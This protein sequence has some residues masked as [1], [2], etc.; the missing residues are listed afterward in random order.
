MDFER[1][2]LTDRARGRWSEIVRALAPHPVMLQAIERARAHP[3]NAYG[4]KTECPVHIGKSGR[5]F[6]VLKDFEQ[7][8]HCVC[9]SCGSKKGFGLLMWL[10]GWDVRQTAVRLGAYL[11][12]PDQH[13][14]ARSVWG[15]PTQA[16]AADSAS[17][18]KGKSRAQLQ[19][20]WD[21]ASGLTDPRAEPVVRY[22]ASRGLAAATS[23]QTL[24]CHPGMPVFVE[25]EQSWRSYPTMLAQ[26]RDVNGELVGMHR[27]FVT[28]AGQK[29]PV[30]SPKRINK[31]AEAL[32]LAGASIQLMPAAPTLGTSEGI[33]NALSV[34]LATG[35]PMW[36]A[37]NATLL[38]ALVVPRW[39]QWL[40]DWA[41]Y[42]ELTQ[43]PN[44]TLVEPG[45]AAAERLIERHR[46]A[47]CR[48]RAVYPTMLGRRGV[49][50]NNVWCQKGSAGFPKLKLSI[51]VLPTVW[52]L[53]RGLLTRK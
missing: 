33:E 24:K 26:Y 11:D 9:N 20:W 6:R 18:P 21:E 14:P 41:D 40:V 2:R 28:E 48:V 13:A 29:A 31:A 36:P 27:T 47:F 43:L 37:G 5:A 30:P 34:F 10:N 19:A 50:W 51:G 8:G 38:G 46:G 49:D 39:V 15:Q 32:S 17:I 42:D 25:S 7:S 23:L 4:Q 52:S 22:L 35:M 3:G 45:R 1:E 12:E 53:A 16:S 44:G